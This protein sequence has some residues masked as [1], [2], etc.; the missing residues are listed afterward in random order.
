MTIVHYSISVYGDFIQNMQNLAS[1]D[2]SRLS[3]PTKELDILL[4]QVLIIS[5]LAKLAPFCLLI[6]NGVAYILLVSR[7]LLVCL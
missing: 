7:L 6:G 1:K 2:Q 5:L 4:T 3:E